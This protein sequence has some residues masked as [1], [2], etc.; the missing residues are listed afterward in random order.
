M[1]G[2]KTR[3]DF[4][5]IFGESEISMQKLHV[6]ST[7]SAERC[8][9]EMEEEMQDTSIMAKICGGDF[10]GIKAQGYTVCLIKYRNEDSQ[11]IHSL[12][13]LYEVRHLYERHLCI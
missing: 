2:D 10:I 7:L 5:C 1:E 12:F 8:L 13:K 4:L 9:M 3:Y 11:K 6:Y